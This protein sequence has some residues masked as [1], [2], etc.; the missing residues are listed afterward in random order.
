MTAA[1]KITNLIIEKIE[2]ENVLPWVKPWT[3]SASQN[4][5]RNFSTGKLYRGINSIILSMAA[6]ATGC[7]WFIT[8]KQTQERGGQVKKGAKGIPVIYTSMYETEDA[9][10]N[11]KKIPFL[12]NYTVFSLKDTTLAVPVDQADE[13]AVFS[14]IEAAEF[15]V[16]GMPTRPEIRFVRGDRACYSPYFDYVEMPEKAQFK[17]EEAYYCT[18][19][20]ELA[21]STGHASRLNRKGVTDSSF[22]GSHSYSREELCAEMSSAFLCAEAGIDNQIDQ[23][24]AYIA[25]WLRALKNDKTFLIKAAAQAQK[26]FD[27]ISDNK[28]SVQLEQFAEAA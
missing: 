25:S 4:A 18:L 1:E 13:D 9:N 20:H 24:A 11:E 5:P 2:S 23:N 26:A 8:F 27:Y 21:H 14:P 15:I 10:G 3:G 19:F 6:Q 17:S 12:R 16:D 28:P 7:K 22:F